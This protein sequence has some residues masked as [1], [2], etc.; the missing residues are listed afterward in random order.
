MTGERIRVVLDDRVVENDLTALASKQRWRIRR[1]IARSGDQPAEYIYTTRDGATD[2]HFIQD[3][4]IGVTYILVKGR[5]A[6]RIA[7]AVSAGL[8]HHEPAMIRAR[9]QRA[10]EA[11]DRRRSLYHL[12][13]IAMDRA[14]DPEVLEIYQRALVDPDPLVRGSAVLG[15][16]YLGWG[17]L[18]GPVGALAGPAEPDPG[19]RRDAALLAG[20]LAQRSSTTE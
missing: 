13:L 16:A 18:A 2:L 1:R 20:R 7:G 8:R 11:M 17:E 9:A 14:V 3:H 19:I 12:A 5:D 6:A 10:T 15:S 4:K